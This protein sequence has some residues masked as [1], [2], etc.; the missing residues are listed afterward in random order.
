MARRL[1][2]GWDGVTVK[3]NS[4]DCSMSETITSASS[5]SFEKGHKRSHP[6][7]ALNCSLCAHASIHGG[8]RVVSRL[9]MAGVDT[10]LGNL[11]SPG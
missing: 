11:G 1:W 2:L 6:S 7:H 3:Q 9:P 10:L 5:G 4:N 8:Y